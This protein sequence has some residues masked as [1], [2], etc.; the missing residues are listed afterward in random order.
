MMVIGLLVGI[1]KTAIGGLGLLCAALIAQIMPA[2]E[3]TGV[4]LL[5]FLT[6][7]LFAIRA[8]KE[9]VE[10]KFL[11]T[12]IWPVLIG[13]VS[14][15][16]YL[17]HSTDSSLKQTIGWV[18]VLLVALYP[19]TQYWQR[20]NEDLSVRFPRTLRIFLGSTAGFMS[21]VAN[22]GGTPMTIYLLLRKKSVLNFLGNTAWF[23]FIL[24]LTK[25]PF[26]L[27]LGL[28]NFSSFHYLYPALP[29]VAIGAFLGKK[30]ISKINQQLFQN[31]TLV[32]AAAVGLKLIFF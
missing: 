1:T 21:M 32:S 10:W 8:Y 31:I 3:S 27:S 29:M 15:A 16:F 22:A 30:I 13:I 12:L 28:L 5:L 4:L 20:H 11:K 9:H 2:K 7:D 6:G 26:T 25:L 14:G 24:N 23:F 17:S 19:A 18:V